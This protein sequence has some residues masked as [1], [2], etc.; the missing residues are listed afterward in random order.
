M[1]PFRSQTISVPTVGVN[2]GFAAVQNYTYDSLDRLKSA[3]ENVT[4]HGGSAAQSWKQTYTFDRYGNR[5]FDFANGNTTFPGPNCPEAICNPTISTSNNRLTSTGWSYDSSG[6]TTADP[7]GRQFTYDA[8]NKQVKVKDSQNQTIGE[9]FYNGDG[10]RIKKIVP[11]TG[12][13]TIFVYDASGKLV[14]EYS[15]IVEPQS[16]AKT[17]YLTTDHLGSPRIL[18]DQNGAVIS[19]RD[20]APYGEELG[21]DIPLPAGTNGHPA[22]T[23][24]QGYTADTIRQKFTGY[25]RDNE[26]ELDF[27]E[28]RYYNPMHGRF[29]SVD[30]EG[31]GA[32]AENPQTWNAY[33]YVG[34]NPVNITDP[35][36]LS[37][38]FNS[39]IGEAGHY[40]W[41]EDNETPAEGYRLVNGSSNH[42]YWAGEGVGYVALN[43]LANKFQIFDTQEAATK[44]VGDIY[45]CPSCQGLVDSVAE[46]SETKGR[47][48]RMAAAVGGA[49]GVCIGTAGVGCAPAIRVATDVVSTEASTPT[50][51]ELNAARRKA[52]KEAWKQEAANVRNGGRGSRNWTAAERQELITTG[53]VKG[54]EGQHVNS[55]NQSPNQAGNP[56]NIKFVKGRQEHLGEHKGNFRNPTRGP[57]IKRK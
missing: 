49:V 10:L 9:Y 48:V 44:R 23:T 13:T 7:E 33:A 39:S 14:A 16:T 35:D 53:K 25:E 30:P 52:V 8:E 11:S 37:W 43:P 32:F 47:T 40:K 12:E 46:N 54:Y 50:T 5:R 34:N 56:N 41:Y 26:S 20:F 4:P 18:T 38:Y 15:T 36:G 19:R 17:S 51:G 6:S 31:A 29:T 2:T 21:V 42:V 28:A 27:A 1:K 22:R 24:Q 57:L 3:V 45:A 55:V